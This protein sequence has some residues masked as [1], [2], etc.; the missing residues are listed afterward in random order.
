MIKRR[1]FFGMALLILICA[2]SLWWR[3]RH[4]VESMASET[5]Q[6]LPVQPQSVSIHLGLVGTL[7]AA[8]A[9][10]MP[11]PFDGT[12]LAVHVQEG[13]Q[14]RQGQ[15]L[16]TLDTHELDIQRRQ[17]L[18]EFLK[19]QA[20]V[21][22][23]EGWRHGAEMTRARRTLSSAQLSLKDTEAKLN[24]TR[25]LFDRGIVPRMEVD[26]LEQQRQAQR[27]DL[28]AAQT[29]LASTQA[30][31]SGVQRQ[32]ADM[33]LLNAQ[34]RLDALEAVY[35][36]RVVLA[37]WAGVVTKPE[38]ATEKDRA[39]IVPV[40][41]KVT[42]GTA[43]LQLA[44]MDSLQV[45]ARVNE[46]DVARL[47]MGM[48]VTVSG[49]GF[50]GYLLAGSIIR[51]GAQAIGGG[52]VGQE[53]VYE[54]LVGLDDMDQVRVAPVRLGMSADLQITLYE[55]SQ[56]V[57]VLP[58]TLRQDEAGNTYVMYRDAVQSAA[59]RV[60]VTNLRTV[61]QG[62]EVSGLSAGFVAVP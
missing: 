15:P 30:Q 36:Q 51:V 39:V 13:Q 49:A 5:V 23:L 6:W 21:D 46:V 20:A 42:S 58:E 50:P 35:A 9:R 55:N 22:V 16:L 27:L 26:A 29:E 62:V 52:L 59:R 12:V 34:T 14:V 31:G 43:L 19:A 48:P 7:Q 28:Q 18:S 37:P 17:A 61:P 11:A 25:R 3:E 1:F 57:V 32:V 47:Q 45:V 40:G 10:I 54:V 44:G 60:D 53:P 8:A 24:D 41:A 38:S 2:V 4:K 56:A 33:E